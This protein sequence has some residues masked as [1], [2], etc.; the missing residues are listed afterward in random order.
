MS[1]RKH[2]HGAA[3]TDTGAHEGGGGRTAFRCPVTS[4]VVSSHLASL[5]AEAGTLCQRSLHEGRR[6]LRV[7][8][9][10]HIGLVS[11]GKPCRQLLSR[12]RVAADEQRCKAHWWRLSVD[13]NSGQSFV[14]I[15]AL[16]HQR[17]LGDQG[18]KNWRRGNGRQHAEDTIA[19]LASREQVCLSRCCAAGFPSCGWKENMNEVVG[20]SKKGVKLESRRGKT[21]GSHQLLPLPRPEGLHP[22]QLPPPPARCKAPPVRIPCLRKPGM[23]VAERFKTV[24]PV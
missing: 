6:H 19:D 5:L 13:G 22:W 12:I 15:T 24:C 8:R 3:I 10:L 2:E 1:C 20:F 17:C 11:M 18:G 23:E 14:H 7:D 4:G 21:W 16:S 9:I